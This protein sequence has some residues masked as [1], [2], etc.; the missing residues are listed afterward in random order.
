MVSIYFRLA[1]RSAAAQRRAK[2]ASQREAQR[3]ERQQRLVFFWAVWFALTFRR[4][5]SAI[6]ARQDQLAKFFD[7]END[8]G[9]ATVRIIA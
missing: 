5:T 9:H 7:K 2:E 4:A 6:E 3:A 8:D 1:A